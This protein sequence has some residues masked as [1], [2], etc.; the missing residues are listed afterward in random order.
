MPR[1][2]YNLLFVSCGDIN[3]LKNCIGQVLAWKSGLKVPLLHL[4]SS[5]PMP[6]ILL[7]DLAGCGGLL[8]RDLGVS[9]T[10]F[11]IEAHQT[12]I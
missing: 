6:A 7:S 3:T 5:C 1:F 2:P 8:Q 12:A 4:G 9:R 10:F 11:Y